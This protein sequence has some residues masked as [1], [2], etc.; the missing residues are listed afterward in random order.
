M[1]YWL[2]TLPLPLA[3]DHNIPSS[4][5][6][7]PA[8]L[9][10]GSVRIPKMTTSGDLTRLRSRWMARPLVHFPTDDISR[11]LS[12]ELENERSKDVCHSLDG[13][14]AVRLVFQTGHCLS[15][16]YLAGETRRLTTCSLPLN[17]FRVVPT[18]IRFAPAP[19]SERSVSGR[20]RR[21]EGR[22]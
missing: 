1:N 21:Q 17:E 7:P 19:S 9:P 12:S 18:N 4:I 22:G 5:S 3:L 15:C 2:S 10:P 14:F 20:A 11:T 8:S 13:E 6:E 16:A